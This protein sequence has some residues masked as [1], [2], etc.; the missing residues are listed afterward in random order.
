MFVDAAGSS[1][2]WGDPL[3]RDPLAVIRDLNDGT[4]PDYAFVHA[5][6]CVVASQDGNGQWHLDTQARLD[7][8][9][10]LRSGRLAEST[11]AEQWWREERRQVEARNFVPEV[12]EMY[13]QS[14]SFA[15][16]RDE[17]TRFWQLPAD[18]SC[19]EE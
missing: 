4:C 8:R 6:H 15:K 7:K 5:M 1:G 2:G 12:T 10:A 3:D 19:G 18:F 17:F 11:P 13:G 14:L 9:A 16:F